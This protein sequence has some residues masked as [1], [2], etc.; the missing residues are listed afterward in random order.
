MGLRIFDRLFRRREEDHDRGY[1][2]G[3][4]YD[5]EE[6]PQTEDLGLLVDHHFIYPSDSDYQKNI[7]KMEFVID[8]ENNTDFPMGN[9]KVEMPKNFK[10]GRFGKPEIPEKLVDPGRKV[11]VMVPYFPKYQ[12]GKDQFEF[13]IS[14]FDFKYKVEERILLKSEPLKV[15]VPKFKGL[16]KDEDGFRLLTGDLYRW[17]TETDVV[18]A[19]PAELYG[20]LTKRLEDIGFTGCDEMVNESLYRGIKKFTATDKKGRKWAA[21]VQVIGRED[22]CKVLIYTYG[23]RPL[24]AYNLAVKLLLKLDG[25]EAILD[26]IDA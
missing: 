3:D 10:L 7:S 2:Q 22:E 23:E 14:F 8:I 9:L 12:G 13:E 21:Q 18:T 15:L 4:Y 17:A 25:R 16:E 19:S 5:Y 11:K 20:S 6:P 26:A 1:D 24:Q